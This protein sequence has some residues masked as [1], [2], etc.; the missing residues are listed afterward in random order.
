M[1][2]EK[3]GCYNEGKKGEG[4]TTKYKAVRRSLKLLRGGRQMRDRA[5]RYTGCQ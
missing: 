3:K 5:G 4:K 2:L 1:P